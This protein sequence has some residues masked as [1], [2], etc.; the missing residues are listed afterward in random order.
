MTPQNLYIYI[1]GY[2]WVYMD[3]L[4]NVY[5]KRFLNFIFYIDSLSALQNYNELNNLC[6]ILTQNLFLVI[7]IIIILFHLPLT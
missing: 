6:Q 1:Y 5:I 4:T 3:A 7:I 2:I